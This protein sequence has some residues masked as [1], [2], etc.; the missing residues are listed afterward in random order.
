MLLQLLQESVQFCENLYYRR[1]ILYYRADTHEDLRSPALVA[2]VNR[3]EPK[4]QCAASSTPEQKPII[5]NVGLEA[6]NNVD[7]VARNKR[8]IYGGHEIK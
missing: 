5:V 3:T 2:L 4:S 7:I 6:Y 8:T 1:E